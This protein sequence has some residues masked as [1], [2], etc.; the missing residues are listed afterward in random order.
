MTRPRK[1]KLFLNF[2]PMTRD[3]ATSRLYTETLERNG[4]NV[5]QTAR[6]CG[7]NESTIR[8]WK[9]ACKLQGLGADSERGE[10]E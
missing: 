3:E 8:R 2:L 6:D 9:E 1:Q 4:G 10:T 5:A 7:V